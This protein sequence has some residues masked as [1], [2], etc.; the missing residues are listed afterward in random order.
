LKDEGATREHNE[1]VNVLYEWNEKRVRGL[2]EEKG[3]SRKR[4]AVWLEGGRKISKGKDA[5]KKR[6]PENDF[7][8]RKVVSKE[9][10]PRLPAT[11]QPVIFESSGMKQNRAA[12]NGQRPCRGEKRM[13]PY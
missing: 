4:S 11:G 9:K 7:G 3:W 6:A 10:G 12:E 8:E 2:G 13:I 5:L 1:K